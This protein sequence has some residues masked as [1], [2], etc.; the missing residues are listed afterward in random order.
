MLSSAKFL[1]NRF[2]IRKKHVMNLPLTLIVLFPRLCE[3]IF[4]FQFDPD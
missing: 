1:I 4:T 3:Q 2:L